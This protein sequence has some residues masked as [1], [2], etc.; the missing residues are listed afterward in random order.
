MRERERQWVRGGGQREGEKQTP[1][2]GGGPT[3]STLGSRPEP[4]ADIQPTEPPKHPVSLWTFKLFFK[5]NTFSWGACVTQSVNI[6]LLVL[7]QVL[8]SEL[9]DGAPCRAPCSAWSLP[10]ILSFFLCLSL[11]PKINQSIFKKNQYLFLS[12]IFTSL[13]LPRHVACHVKRFYGHSECLQCTLAYY[14]LQWKYININLRSVV[15]LRKYFLHVC[16]AWPLIPMLVY[17]FRLYWSL[18]Y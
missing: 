15:Y 4:N 14:Q 12:L 18:V 17:I 3:P 13:L 5:I 6:R 10:G 2:Q 9:W 8:I 1:H 11:T 16:F 7:A